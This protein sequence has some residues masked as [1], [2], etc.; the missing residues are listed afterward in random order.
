MPCLSFSRKSI[1]HELV[2]RVLVVLGSIAGLLP[3]DAP[4]ELDAAAEIIEGTQNGEELPPPD[5]DVG[6]RQVVHDVGLRDRRLLSHGDEVAVAAVVLQ[7]GN[8]I[9]HQ[10]RLEDD[11]T[12][13]ITRSLLQFVRFDA[14]CHTDGVADGYQTFS[15][16]DI[17]HQAR[18]IVVVDIR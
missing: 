6:R 13:L 2:V 9:L 15:G 18:E 8:D 1:G 11:D 10:F 5:P 16:L 7:A 14:E 3:V 17:T 12:D 4:L